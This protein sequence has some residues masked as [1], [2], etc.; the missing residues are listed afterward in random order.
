MEFGVASRGG[1]VVRRARTIT[2]SA[3]TSVK[4]SRQF[5]VL[6]DP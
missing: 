2:S 5:Y 1:T 6:V 4:P 3:V